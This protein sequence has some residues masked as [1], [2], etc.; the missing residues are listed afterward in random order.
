MKN[1]SKQERGKNDLELIC[2]KTIQYFKDNQDTLVK[3]ALIAILL[4][5][6]V[7]FAFRFR[8]DGAAA[9]NKVD[10]AYYTA[11][12]GT[13]LGITGA[14]DPAPFEALENS[15][16][17]ASKPLL[18]LAAADSYAKR[19][20]SE[21]RIRF[22]GNSAPLE[23]ASTPGDPKATLEKALSI[24]NE[25][26]NQSGDASDVLARALYG[27]GITTE[28]LASITKEEASVESTLKSAVSLYEKIKSACSATPYVK[29]AENRIK[30]LAEPIT[31][32]YY[33][34]IAKKYAELPAPKAPEKKDEKSILSPDAKAPLAP[35]KDKESK[36]VNEFSLNPDTKAADKPAD[37]AA[38]KAADKP[39]DKK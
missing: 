22:S 35:P 37:K 38:P 9:Q 13:M 11:M 26:A 27:A 6:A 18:Q 7:I 24:Y 25:V 10:E 19:G 29:P 21:I 32:E 17:K 2:L 15:S 23:L 28:Y 20:I 36:I 30:N 3:T 16:D 14:P 12:N 5:V 31:A 33:K 4:V 1:T 34:K 39:V 8:K